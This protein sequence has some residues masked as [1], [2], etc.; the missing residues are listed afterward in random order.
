LTQRFL[1]EFIFLLFRRLDHVMSALSEG[2]PSPT[3]ILVLLIVIRWMN[4]CSIAHVVS[5]RS[6]RR[7]SLLAIMM[8]FLF[9]VC[10]E[11]LN[12]CVC[13]VHSLLLVQPLLTSSNL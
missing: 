12:L 6:P 3:R 2:D 7:P 13:R 10:L 11:L 1:C 5:A 4:Q 8:I 9:V